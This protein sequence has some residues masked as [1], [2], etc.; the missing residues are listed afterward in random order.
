MPSQQ[1][2]V[3]IIARPAAAAVSGTAWEPFSSASSCL[4]LLLWLLP[5]FVA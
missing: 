1:E 5:L 3:A 4:L 2:P